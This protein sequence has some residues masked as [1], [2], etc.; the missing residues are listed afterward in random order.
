MHIALFGGSFDPIHHGHL[1]I[2]KEA[3]KQLPISAVWFMPSKDTPLKQ[4]TL[5]SFYDR[6]KMIKRAIRPYRRMHLCTIEN[7]RD[8][9]SYTIDT[10]MLLKKKY[11]NI[12]F[13]LL[14]GDDQAKQF[15]LWKHAEKLKLE[16]KVYVFSREENMEL[17][18]GLH[19]IK[20]PLIPVSSTQIRQGK[21][22]SMICKSVHRYIGEKGLYLEDMLRCRMSEKRFLHSCSVA[23]LCVEIAKAHQLDT[24]KAY[25]MGMAHDICKQ[26]PYATAKSMMQ[27]LQPKELD[28]AVAIWHGYLGA[29]STKHILGIY[30]KKVCQAIYHHVKGDGHGAYDKILFVADKLDPLRGYP[31]DEQIALCKQDLQAGFQLVKQQQIVYLEKQGIK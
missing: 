14:I 19:R 2:A 28:E 3:L 18:E 22:L 9:V 5:S 29:Y 30:D 4:R 27:Y 16:V 7:E 12:T 20:M 1:Q 11:P 21:Q 10:I 8:D 24:H 15:H 13:S 26:L 17:P 25:V 23:K 6:C 31:V